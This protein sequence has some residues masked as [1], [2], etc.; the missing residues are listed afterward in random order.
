MDLFVLVLMPPS[1]HRLLFDPLIMSA[2][3]APKLQVLCI[4]VTEPVDVL[5]QPFPAHFRVQR[6]QDVA[7]IKAI[8][9]VSMR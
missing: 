2:S 5:A 9:Q 1:S 7:T 8:L 6:S 4:L 3:F